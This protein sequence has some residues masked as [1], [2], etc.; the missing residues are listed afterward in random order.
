MTSVSSSELP[1]H[2]GTQQLVLGRGTPLEVTVPRALFTYN[3][4]MLQRLQDAW[5]VTPAAQADTLRSLFTELGAA[6]LL[7]SPTT[8]RVERRNF[9]LMRAL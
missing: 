3:Q 9:R 5:L 1:R 7:D 4:W 2:C 6:A 8:L